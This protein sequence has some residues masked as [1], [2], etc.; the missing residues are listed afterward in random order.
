MQQTWEVGLITSI[1]TNEE[2]PLP[3]LSLCSFLHL[4]STANAFKT[5][6][7]KLFQDRWVPPI[8]V[9][10]VLVYKAERDMKTNNCT[11]KWLVF[12]ERDNQGLHGSQEG[13]KKWKMTGNKEKRRQ[14]NENLFLSSCLFAVS[15]YIHALIKSVLV[16]LW[17]V[18]SNREDSKMRKVNGSVLGF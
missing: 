17:K 3:A 10:V 7:Q 14:K 1:F 5:W 12:S 11:M 15:I 4:C 8:P 16:F 2:P 18:N 6:F 9:L 13:T